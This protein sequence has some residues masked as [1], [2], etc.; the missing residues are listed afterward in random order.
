M[1]IDDELQTYDE[2]EMEIEDEEEY[3]QMEYDSDCSITHSD[4]PMSIWKRQI[5][6]GIR[7][8]KRNFIEQFFFI[9]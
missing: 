5:N 2:D 4:K 6:R 1:E 7:H 3:Y 8:I 9:F